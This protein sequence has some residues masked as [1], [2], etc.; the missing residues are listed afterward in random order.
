[1]V[2]GHGPGHET[3]AVIFLESNEGTYRGTLEAMPAVPLALGKRMGLLWGVYSLA[4]VA[5]GRYRLGIGVDHAT[6]PAV[7]WSIYSV[8]VE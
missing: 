7:V 3:D 5:P 4:G 2:N 8:D 6:A 1:L